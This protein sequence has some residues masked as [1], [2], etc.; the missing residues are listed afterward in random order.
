MLKKVNLQCLYYS[1]KLFPVQYVN[2]ILFT[3][4]SMRYF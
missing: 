3:H 4:I 1:I 2:N